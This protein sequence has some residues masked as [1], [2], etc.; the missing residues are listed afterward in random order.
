[1]M[2]MHGYFTFSLEKMIWE[3]QELR[4]IGIFPDRVLPSRPD[5]LYKGD[6]LGVVN[7]SKKSFY[8]Y[9]IPN[10]YSKGHSYFDLLIPTDYYESKDPVTI[11]EVST[12]PERP[13]QAVFIAYTDSF[14]GVINPNY[15][16]HPSFFADKNYPCLMLF[17]IMQSDRRAM[18]RIGRRAGPGELQGFSASTSRQERYRVCEDTAPNSWSLKGP[19]DKDGNNSDAVACDIWCWSDRL[20]ADG[21]YRYYETRLLR[22]IHNVGYVMTVPLDIISSQIQITYVLTQYWL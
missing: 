16:T 21:E 17:G 7:S 9:V 12:A 20:R 8:H 10:I 5:T 11:R 19:L 22:V 6:Y 14:Q 4:H 2:N 1:M 18:V 3:S 15:V 13:Q